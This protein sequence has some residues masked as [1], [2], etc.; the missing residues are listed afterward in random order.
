MKIPK[1][2]YAGIYKIVCKK[3]KCLYIGKAKNIHKR[4]YNHLLFLEGKQPENIFLAM[5]WLKYGKKSFYCRV[6][7][8]VDD[9][10]KLKERE[11]AIIA[12]HDF[13]LLYNVR[14]NPKRFPTIQK[15]WQEYRKKKSIKEKRRL[16]RLRRL[17]KTI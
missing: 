4:L 1:A 17:G 14:H 11:K 2:H 13:D 12:M 6:I 9:L 5:D 10:S 15:F 7:E 16:A 3:N 8:R